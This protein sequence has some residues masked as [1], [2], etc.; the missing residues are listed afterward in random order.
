MT[1]SLD[2]TAAPT[3]SPDSERIAFAAWNGEEATIHTVRYDGEDLRRVWDGRL[4][5]H[6]Y[7]PQVSWSPDGSELFFVSDHVYI[8]R[9]DGSGV[10]RFPGLPAGAH[11]VAAWSPDGVKVCRLQDR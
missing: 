10:R 9:L 7:F 6:L 2:P 1:S 8:V 11:T 4:N 5:D 3:W